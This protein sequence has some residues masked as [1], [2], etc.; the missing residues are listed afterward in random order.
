[1]D[2]NINFI[3]QCIKL[4]GNQTSLENLLLLLNESNYIDIYTDGATQFDGIKRN[5]GIG[6]YFKDDDQRNL[7]QIVNTKDNNECEIMACI[8]ALKIVINSCHFINIFTDSR[9]VVD[10]MNG[11]C[12]SNKCKEL[13]DKLDILNKQFIDVKY[14]YVKGH[15]DNDGNNKADALSRSLF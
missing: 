6:V 2:N 5:S 8:E 13:F 9:L 1:M 4:Y 3:K 15:S 10:R 7:A 11:I 14:I 12:H